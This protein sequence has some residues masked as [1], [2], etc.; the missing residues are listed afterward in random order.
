MKKLYVRIFDD[1]EDRDAEEEI[2]DWLEEIEEEANI[3]VVSINQSFNSFTCRTVISI[4]F[5]I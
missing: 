2:N 5:R 4:F 3:E 1:V